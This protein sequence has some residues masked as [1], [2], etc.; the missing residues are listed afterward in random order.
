MLPQQDLCTGNSRHLIICLVLERLSRPPKEE[1]LLLGH[2]KE[3]TLGE[4]GFTYDPK[5]K[6]TFHL[7]TFAERGVCL[8]IACPLG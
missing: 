5:H 3:P 7:F 8:P 4:Y 1:E 2:I 6:R